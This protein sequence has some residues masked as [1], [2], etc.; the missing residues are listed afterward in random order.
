MHKLL[1]LLLFALLFFASCGKTRYAARAADD[2]V[3]HCHLKRAYIRSRS[4][5]TAGF[6]ASEK[7]PV[8]ESRNA[9][10]D[11][12]Q[13]M[14]TAVIN[15]VMSLPL[16]TKVVVYP[17]DRKEYRQ[18]LYWGDNVLYFP[19]DS[20]KE[21]GLHPMRIVVSGDRQLD[22]VFL[23]RIDANGQINMKNRGD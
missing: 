10:W 5:L 18:R 13:D 16:K 14:F 23:F 7:D 22:H 11:P 12:I 8:P 9:G 4:D 17:G 20:L 19:K 1:I 2:V 6:N 3:A 15:G 21:N